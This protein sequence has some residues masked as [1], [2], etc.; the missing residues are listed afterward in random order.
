MCDKYL[1]LTPDMTPNDSKRAVIDFENNTGMF[2]LS[3]YAMD[4]ILWW[5]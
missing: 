1:E 3:K 4:A 2:I 5:H